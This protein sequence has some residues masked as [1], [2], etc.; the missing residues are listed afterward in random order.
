MSEG[1]YNSSCDG[2]FHVGI[3]TVLT[4]NRLWRETCNGSWRSVCDRWWRDWW[5]F[6]P[7]SGWDLSTWTRSSMKTTSSPVCPPSLMVRLMYLRV[8]NNNQVHRRG[9]QTL[10]AASIL[11]NRTPILK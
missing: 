3:N 11:G 9:T 1:L 6:R 7:T 4:V 5:M 10:H 8:Y 2:L